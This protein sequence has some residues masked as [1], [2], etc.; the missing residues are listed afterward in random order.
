MKL[1]TPLNTAMTAVALVALL[2][3][4]VAMAKEEAGGWLGVSLQE[5]NSSLAKAYG[6]QEEGG[7]LVNEVIADSPAARA[8]LADGDVIISYAGRPID[9]TS[10]LVEAVR[11]TTPGETVNVVVV[12]EG[13]RL[14]LPVEIAE[15][16]AG[17]RYALRFEDDDQGTWVIGEGDDHVVI[18]GL[19]GGKDWTWNAMALQAD[20][21]YL[22]VQLDDLN[23]QLGEYF[24]VAR[25]EGALI[26]EVIADSPAQKAGFKA[27]DVIVDFA[28][29][30]VTSAVDLHV[31]IAK[32]EPQ[33]EVRVKVIRKGKPKEIK[34]TLGEMPALEDLSHLEMIAPRVKLPHLPKALKFRAPGEEQQIIIERMLEGDAE[35]MEELGQEMQALREELKQMQHELQELK[36]Q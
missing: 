8:G 5:L 12:R 2:T 34:V 25:G 9:S 14:T 15:N 3:A 4:G 23:E 30:P 26:T 7:V 28:G 17:T 29:K 24:E 36:K 19:P 6:L 18:K 10:D 27:G 11:K 22:G 1:V 20:R 33:Q 16:T 31:A 21:G 13:T 35:D 32:T